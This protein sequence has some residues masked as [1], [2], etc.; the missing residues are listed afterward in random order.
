MQ[1]CDSAIFLISPFKA[2]RLNQDRYNEKRY[3]TAYRTTV[4]SITAV[5]VLLGL[6]A[7]IIFHAGTFSAY[8]RENIAVTV[9]LDE[10]A[11]ENVIFAIRDSIGQHEAV[12]AVKYVTPAEAT[13]IL[14]RELG[15]DFLDF[16][17]FNP[18]PPTLEVF[19]HEEYTFSD[20]FQVVENFLL[21][22]KIV[23]A[24][25]YE[26]DLLDKVNRN[27]SRITKGILMFSVILLIISVLLINNTI[28]LAVY[29][30]RQLIKSMYLVGAT[31]AFIRRP[32]IVGGILQGLTGGIIT[33]FLLLG[34]L[35]LANQKLPE[36]HLFGRP[37]I[38]LFIFMGIIL[39]GIFVTWA[40]NYIAVKKYLG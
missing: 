12:K 27:I 19:L 38:S 1:S 36:L 37:F 31:Q 13:E 15:D 18:I 3:R 33:V 24:V 5:L 28:R 40:S 10:T 22:Q 29:S 26:K 8:I 23:T 32:F 35:L 39:F 21:S 6:T 30:K 14:R 11:A 34:I 4:F 16:L 7:M 20:R 9:E 2:M 25:Y 17:D